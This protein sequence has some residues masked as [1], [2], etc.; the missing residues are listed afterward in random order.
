MTPLFYEMD[1]SSSY[2]AEDVDFT[3]FLEVASLMGGHNTVEEF[4]ASG[5][6]T[7]GQQFGFEVETKESHLSKAVV[8]MP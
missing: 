1:V 6:W 8:L 3:A 5:L 2:D 4:L 7:L